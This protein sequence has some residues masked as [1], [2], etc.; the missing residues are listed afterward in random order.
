M[1]A[2]LAT[3]HNSAWTALTLGFFMLIASL[4]WVLDLGGMTTRYLRFFYRKLG[5]LLWPSGSEESY[6]GFMRYGGIFV[7]VGATII[8]IVGITRL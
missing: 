6:V 4:A 3:A 5:R 8:V 2:L 1:K 7:V